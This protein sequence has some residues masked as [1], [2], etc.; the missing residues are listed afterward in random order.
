MREWLTQGKR[1]EVQDY[2]T[3]EVREEFVER[4][5]RDGFEG[6]Q[7]WYKAQVKNFNHEDEK[8]VAEGKDRVDVPFLF[9]G[10]K[11]D[12]VCPTG[13]IYGSIEA[14]LLPDCEVKEVETGHWSTLAAPKEVGEIVTKWLGE[15][16]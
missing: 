11:F 16:Y 12:S 8:G 1:Q 2:A 13:L 9:V 7:C 5:T 14:G 4:F 3:E 10:G 6:P 15:K